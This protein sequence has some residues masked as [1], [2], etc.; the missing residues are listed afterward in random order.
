LEEWGQVIGH[1]ADML[2]PTLAPASSG[3]SDGTEALCHLLI[4]A[5]RAWIERGQY[6]HAQAA[7]QDADGLARD[8]HLLH[9]EAYTTHYVGHLLQH[10]GR[11][12][13]ARPQLERALA[14]SR[15]VPVPDI[16]ARTLWQL[17][18]LCV[19]SGEYAQAQDYY[20][21]AL[22]I[23]QALGD[24]LGEAAVRCSFGTLNC[25]LGHMA[26]ARTYLEESLCAYRGLRHRAGERCA[27]N[28]LALVLDEDPACSEAADGCVAQALTIAQELG[29]PQ[30][31]SCSL[32][33]LGRHMLRKGD[34]VQARTAFAQ[35]LA[36]SESCETDENIV[37]ALWGL[38]LVAHH[39]GNERLAYDYSQ[40]AVRIAQEHLQRRNERFAL[41]LMGHALAGL[42]ELAQATMV[43]QQVLELDRSLGYRHL[44]VET[45]ADLAR[46]TLAQGDVEQ[47][48]AF[49]A[50]IVDRLMEHDTAG[51]EEPLLLYVTCYQVLRA[52]NDQRAD[53]LLAA[54]DSSPHAWVAQ[55]QDGERPRTLLENLPSHR[56][57]WHLWRHGRRRNGRAPINGTNV[58]A[59]EISYDAVRPAPQSMSRSRSGWITLPRPAFHL[60][61]AVGGYFY[62]NGHT[63]LP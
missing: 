1:A 46:V 40:Q 55:I 62:S 6:D 49:V 42:G 48:H 12:D 11:S 52:H 5:G 35:A 3:R 29:N 50:S 20:A 31:H 59:E 37:V 2:R 23:Y 14:L 33:A 18:Q 8:Y 7:L 32:N 21:S 39:E 60:R 61:N 30:G 54:G 57:L 9:L 22:P 28:G 10:R 63:L 16:E 26:V 41:R 15:T 19:S 58:S 56:T 25:E 38:G 44:E 51:V 36:I 17:G 43:Y 24:R 47:A 27:L 34:P 53:V 13:A 4:D 45:T